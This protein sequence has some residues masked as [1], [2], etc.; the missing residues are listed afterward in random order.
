MRKH[1]LVTSPKQDHIHNIKMQGPNGIRLLDS[2]V[3]LA[4]NI[5]VINQFLVAK[6]PM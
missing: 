1:Q 5:K 3:G 2:L 6:L 4:R